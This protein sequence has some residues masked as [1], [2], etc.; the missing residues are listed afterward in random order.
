MSEFEPTEEMVFSEEAYTQQFYDAVV[1]AQCSL[2]KIAFEDVDNKMRINISEELDLLCPFVE[3]IVCMNGHGIVAKF[4]DEGEWSDDIVVHT[5]GDTDPGVHMGVRVLRDPDNAKHWLIMHQIC[6]ESEA[7]VL[8]QTCVQTRKYFSYFDMNASVTRIDELEDIFEPQQQ[9][10]D[11]EHTI[12]QLDDYQ[13]RI[14]NTVRSTKFRRMGR[15]AQQ[16]TLETL[17]QQA[18]DA[19]ALRDKELVLLAEYGYARVVEP[20]IEKFVPL[21]TGTTIIRGLC[22]GMISIDYLTTAQRAI[23]SDK[24]R[25]NPE[26]ALCLVV[27]PHDK[28]PLR[29]LPTALIYIP[30]GQPIEFQFPGRD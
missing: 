22:L 30:T 26:A 25:Q 9:E 11:S 1:A 23:R 16:R 24:D 13:R 28:E 27:D 17:I 7:E 18:E 4:D 12:M 14:D 8:G 5:R 20:G 10:P 29:L 2:N 6:H 19:T 3:D 21:I 15:K